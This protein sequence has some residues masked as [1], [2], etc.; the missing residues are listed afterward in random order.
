MSTDIIAKL[1][2]LG[3]LQA[4][5]AVLQLDYRDRRAEIMS[6]VQSQLDALDQELKP[7]IAAAE[8][9]AAQLEGEVKALVIERGAS[10]K[11]ERLHAVY[12]KGRV[13]WDTKGL[14]GFVVAHP[15]VAQFRKEGQPSVTIRAA[16]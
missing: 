1:D 5:A 6:A 15:E 3:E 14:D 2:R 7:R 9:Q 8:E 16:K 11:G 12:S 10:V 13:T 4:A